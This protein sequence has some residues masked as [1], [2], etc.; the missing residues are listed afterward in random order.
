MKTHVCF[1][2]HLARKFQKLYGREN[3]SDKLADKKAQHI[4]VILPT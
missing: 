1:S 2:P 3:V 4:S